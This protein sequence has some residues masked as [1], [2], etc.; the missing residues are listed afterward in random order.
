M[1]SG[2]NYFQAENTKKIYRQ[3]AEIQEKFSL[4][5]Y[6]QTTSQLD[7]LE[8]ELER[9]MTSTPDILA[10]MISKQ[11]ERLANHADT[12]ANDLAGDLMESAKDQLRYAKIDFDNKKFSQSYSELKDAITK[13]DE[14]DYRLAMETYSEKANEILEN[15]GKTMN[16]FSGVLELGPTM[17]ESFSSG[18]DGHVRYISISSAL[19]PAQFRATVTELYQKARILEVP[20]GAEGVHESLVDMLNDIRLA[21]VYFDKMCILNEFDPASRHEIIF[22]AFDYINSAK[23]KRAELQNTFLN[24][25]KKLRLAEGSF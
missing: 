7:K 18:P 15:L 9:L 25:D 2:V 6:D 13:L 24:R 12:K 19:P 14:V 23:Q 17:V 4:E 16:K 21:S 8:A 20:K 3:V 11:Q 5:N 22:K 10:K 1:H